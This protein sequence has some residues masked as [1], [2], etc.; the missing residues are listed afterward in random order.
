[1]GSRRC[2]PHP[3]RPQ[4]RRRTRGRPAPRWARRRGWCRFHRHRGRRDGPDDGVGRH[5]RRARTGPARGTVAGRVGSANSPVA[6]AP[7]DALPPRRHR[8]GGRAHPRRVPDPA[9]RRNRARRGDRGRR[10]RRE[11]CRRLAAR[12]RPAHRRRRGVR[13]V[14]S[15]GSERVRGRGRR[16]LVPTPERSGCSGRAL[17]Q[18]HRAGRVRGAQHRPPRTTA[19]PREPRL[20]LDRP[21]R[22]PPRATRTTPQRPERPPRAAGPRRAAGS[23]RAARCRRP[24]RSRRRQ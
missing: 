8:D 21:I 1:M 20:R 4:R 12:L 19:V 7:G 6:R 17:D 22:R 24:V 9:E 2:D 10:P 3:A 16:P 18:R 15:R 13:P 14:R 11:P 5:A 23:R